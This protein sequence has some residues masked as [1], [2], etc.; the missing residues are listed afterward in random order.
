MKVKI[1]LYEHSKRTGIVFDKNESANS[2]EIHIVFPFEWLVTHKKVFTSILA[3]AFIQRVHSGY[4]FFISMN[5]KCVKLL[6]G[7][8]QK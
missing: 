2:Y 1:M 4:T 3:D 8:T 7:L 6:K 5:I